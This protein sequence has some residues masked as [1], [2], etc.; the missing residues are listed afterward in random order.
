MDLQDDANMPICNLAKTMHHAWSMQSGK[1]IVDL[2]EQ[3]LNDLIRALVESRYKDYFLGRNIRHGPDNDELR[4]QA[5][6]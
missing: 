3:Q 1:K 2:Y 6:N 4:L 5:T